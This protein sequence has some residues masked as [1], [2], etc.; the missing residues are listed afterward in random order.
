LLVVIAI[1]AVLIGLLLP[2]VQ[3]A[4]ESASR[5]QSENNLHQIAIAFH[6]YHDNYGELPH[7]GTW[8]NSNWIWGPGLGDWVHTLPNPTVSPGTTWAFKLL[9]YI[10]ETNLYNHYAFG[11]P[12]RTYLDPGRAG[13]GISV[14]QWDGGADN[15]IYSA[16]QVT[17]YAANSMLI[18]SGI[19]TEGPLTAPVAGNEWTS[20]PTTGW[21]AFRR[22]LITITDGT[23]NT[24]MVGTKAMAT[25]V[26]LN[27]GCST[28]N[29]S[30]GT[31]QSCND[32]PITNPGPAVMGL[33]RSFGPDDT[34]WVAG[35]SNGGTPFTGHR[36]YLQ[37]GWNQWFYFT[38]AFEQDATDLDSWNRW[39]GPYTAVVPIAMCDASVRNFS[40]S[41][42]NTIVLQLSTPVGGEPVQ[43]PN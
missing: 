24:I 42:S 26:Y 15:S 30:N 33:M 39:G 1:I 23:E 29:M 5:T 31:T 36:Y 25:Q 12:I 34:F 38:F 32:D 8:N 4:R 10:E 35:S 3:K 27:R 28:F 7:N 16:G 2:A 11:S 21:V 20:A 41:T 18:G 37:S 19:N 6:T 14:N 13:G 22:R 17:D 43:L 9:P 40:Y